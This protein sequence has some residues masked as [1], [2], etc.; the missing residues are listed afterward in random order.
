[1]MVVERALP[2]KQ[3]ELFRVWSSLSQSAV[4]TGGVACSPWPL[5][6]TAAVAVILLFS[7]NSS[8]NT[9]LLLQCSVQSNNSWTRE[10]V[11]L[12]KRLHV[13]GTHEYSSYEINAILLRSRYK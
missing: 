13:D 10:Y 8:R 7:T 11:G 4:M 9:V 3:R 5:D 2:R 1:M 6:N 12:E